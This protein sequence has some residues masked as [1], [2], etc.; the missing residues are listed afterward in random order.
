MARLKIILT[1]F[2]FLCFYGILVTGS[3]FSLFGLK[4]FNRQSGNYSA[5]IVSDDDNIDKSA[6]HYAVSLSCGRE[7]GSIRNI[8]LSPKMSRILDFDV[9]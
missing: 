4:S 8:Q 3:N 2:I 7:S 1:L 5:L 9:S 6:T